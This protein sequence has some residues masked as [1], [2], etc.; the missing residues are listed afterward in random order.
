MKNKQDT[1]VVCVGFRKNNLPYIQ[2]IFDKLC[3]CQWTGE[4][5]GTP[6]SFLDFR[7]HLTELKVKL[8]V[9]S[10]FFT[11]IN[12]SRICILSK[13]EIK[14]DDASKAVP[15]L[16]MKVFTMSGTQIKKGLEITPQ[17]ARSYEYHDTMEFV[18]PLTDA[19]FKTYLV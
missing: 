18:I 8:N 2:D 6:V 13:N 17:G 9:K 11:F 4:E 19:D 1:I 5:I 7:I 12:G 3:N 15:H 16:F 14:D 10:V